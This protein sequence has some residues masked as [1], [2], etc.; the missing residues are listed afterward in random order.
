MKYVWMSLTS[1]GIY[2][3]CMC[4]FY[5]REC[6]HPRTKIVAITVWCMYTY[7]VVYV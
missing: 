1:E 4:L 7:S 2:L 5:L 3:E 6:V